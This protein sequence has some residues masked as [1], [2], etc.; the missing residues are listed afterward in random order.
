MNI[1]FTSKWRS[2]SNGFTTFVLKRRISVTQTGSL[3][4][5]LRQNGHDKRLVAYFVRPVNYYAVM[6]TI[7]RMQ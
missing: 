2:I 1:H 4:Q 3:S 5:G 7:C 6:D